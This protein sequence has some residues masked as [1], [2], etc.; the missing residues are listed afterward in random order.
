[1]GRGGARPGA[2]RKPS[3]VPTTT[4][5]FRVDVELKKALQKKAREMGITPT[6]L[7][8]KILETALN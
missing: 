7:M 4:V 8:N 3:P 5:A 2:G 6:I 1:M